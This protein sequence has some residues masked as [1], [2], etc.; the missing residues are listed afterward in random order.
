MRARLRSRQAAHDSAPDGRISHVALETDGEIQVFDVWGSQEAF[1]AFG[2][3][4]LPIL[5]AAGVEMNEPMVAR[6]HNEIK[7]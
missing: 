6:V 1:D 4:L 3:T 7:S 5:A 2:V